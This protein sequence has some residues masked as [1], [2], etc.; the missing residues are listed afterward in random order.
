ML[1]MKKRIAFIVCFFYTLCV[2]SQVVLN[3]ASINLQNGAYLVLGDNAPSALSVSNTNGGI[4][5]DANSFVRWNI[6]TTSGTYTIPY[7]FNGDYI[8]VSFTTSGSIGTGYFDLNTYNVPTWKNSDYLPS[9]VTNVNRNG[10]DNSNHL[11]DR[12]WSLA[13]IGYTTKPTISSLVFTYRDAEWNGAGNSITET[14][15]KAQRW[16]NTLSRWDDYAPA[17]IATTTANTVTISSVASADLYQWWALVD[18]AFPLPLQL[19]TFTARPEQHTALLN[20]STSTE[21]NTSH[22]IIERSANGTQF[23]PLCSVPAA[24]F[25]NNTLHYN[26]R[27]N[28]ALNGTSYY[29]LKMVDRDSSFKYSSIAVVQIGATQI[30]VF[31]NPV[32]DKLYVQLGTSNGRV[33]L[34]DA[35]GKTIIDKGKGSGVVPVDLVSLSVGVYYVV[36]ITDAEQKTFRIVKAAK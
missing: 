31:P 5:T 23:L 1:K 17:G 4:I 12:F 3:G 16:N 25:S 14:L 18:A 11:V 30:T 24:G 9:G 2:N 28:F 20:W 15:L 36:V 34:T 8:P 13:A 33:L 6:G 29:R 7:F 35:A 10:V 21:I 19:L 26:A 27:D 22:F 32:Q